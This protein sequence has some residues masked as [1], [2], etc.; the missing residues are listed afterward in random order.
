[1]RTADAASE[2]RVTSGAG[3]D[4]APSELTDPLVVVHEHA[5]GEDGP[6]GI[7]AGVTVRGGQDSA[8]RR[9][10]IHHFPDRATVPLIDHRVQGIDGEN[11]TA[12]TVR[13]GI[14]STDGGRTWTTVGCSPD[15]LRASAMAMVDS[16]EWAGRHISSAVPLSTT[17]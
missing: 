2:L 17:A 12:A 10:V 9:A 4:A 13:V 8:P 16:C 6:A 5:Q 7:K 14:D 1:M 11:G 15:I 3:G